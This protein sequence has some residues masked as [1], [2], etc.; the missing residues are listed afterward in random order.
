MVQI[1][2]LERVYELGGGSRPGS[3]ICVFGLIDGGNA[4][5]L[6]IHGGCNVE[7]E[8]GGIVQEVVRASLERK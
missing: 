3:N 1:K 2:Q 8:G 6:L 4:H 7:E 5:K